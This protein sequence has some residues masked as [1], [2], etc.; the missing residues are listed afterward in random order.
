VEQ[1]EKLA[2]TSK[3][4]RRIAGRPRMRGKEKPFVA[5][6]KKKIQKR[7]RFRIGQTGWDLDFGLGFGQATGGVAALWE[8]NGRRAGAD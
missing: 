1:G 7:A 8:W 4:V 2:K 3:V 5:S 6:E